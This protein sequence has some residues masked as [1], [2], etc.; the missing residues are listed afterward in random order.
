MR[1]LFKSSMFI[2]VAAMAF[3]GC[4][5][6]DTGNV[7]EATGNKITVNANAYAP[8]T[9]TRTVIGDKTEQGTYPVYWSAEN[10]ALAIVE[11]ADNTRGT[12]I[13]TGEYTLSEDKKNANFQ[14]ELTENTSATAF[15]YYALYPYS[16]WSEDL[17]TN[18]ECISFKFPAAQTPSATSVDPNAS[19]LFAKSMGHIAQPSALNL[20]FQHV[21]A[22]AKMTITGLAVEPDE[23]V[24]SVTFSSTDKNLAGTYKYFHETPETSSISGTS[25]NSITANVEGLVSDASQDFTVWFA[26]LPTTIGDTFSVSVQTDANIYTREVTVPSDRPLEFVA[27]QVSTFGV[28]M[29]SAGLVEDYSGDYIILAEQSGKYYALANTYEVDNKKKER[30]DAVLFEYNG[31]DESI[32]TDN[33][34]VVWTVSKTGSNYTFAKDGKYLSWDGR[35]NVALLA[36]AEYELTITKNS[37]TTYTISPATDSGRKLAKNNTMAYFAFYSGS[38]TNEL[39]LIPATQIVLPTIV[40]DAT[41]LSI[42]YNDETAHEF[43]VTVSDAT[44]VVAAAYDDAEGT[45]EC[46]WL[47]AEYAEG[48]VTYMAEANNTDTERSA[49]IIVTAANENGSKKVV[50]PVK[51]ATATL[52]DYILE[53]GAKYNSAGV[54]SYSNNWSVTK[55]GYTWNITNCNNNNNGWNSVRAGAKKATTTATITTSWA[56]EQAINSVVI[57]HSILRGS[58]NAKL[59]VASDADFSS[60]VDQQEVDATG[61]ELTF[62]ISTPTANCYYK[63]E[64]VCNNTSNSNGVIE[65]NN[66]IYKLN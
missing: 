64:F 45:T 22:Y 39:L 48:K 65:I 41:T 1:N 34:N 5:K 46:S 10:E 57:T 26:C 21:A 49:Y 31:T 27:G 4:T 7:S 40:T 52:L 43:N 8:E 36:E 35:S 18:K 16:V 24:K 53:F 32:L 63:L 14:F 51:Q 17:M 13:K 44:S 66:V 30:L 54:S 2:A 56:I 15:D 3:A 38:G 28:D 29:S 55:D 60:I 11:F 58:C 61:G 47:I 6:E 59:T 9:E 23:V 19:V 37:E 33:S 20:S 62:T 12:A 42:E 25:Y 50:I